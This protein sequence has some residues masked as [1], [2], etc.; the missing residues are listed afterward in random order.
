M[1]INDITKKV[2]QLANTWEEF[3]S[4]NERRLSEIE[5]KSVSDPLTTTQLEKINKAMDRYQQSIDNI[6]AVLNRP[7]V[8]SGLMV[9]E[10]SANREY[11]EAFCK[12][13]KNGAEADLSKLEKKSLVRPA[14]NEAG[15]SIT[16][17]MKEYI[18]AL[19]VQNSSM[20]QISNVIE[21]ST[22]TLEIIEDREGITSGWTSGVSIDESQETAFSK[23]SVHVHELYVQPKVTQKLIDDPMVDVEEWLS[24]KLVNSFVVQENKAFISGDGVGKPRGILS[25]SNI[26]KVESSVKDFNADKVLEL[27]FSIKEIYADDTKFLMSRDALQKIRTLKDKNGQ[28]LWHPNLSQ[29]GKST[30]FGVDVKV[31]TDMPKL[32]VD[33]LPIA[34]GNFNHAYQIVDR[35]VMRVLRDPFTNK[36]FV[37][38]YTTKRV[39][40]DVVNFDSIK[41]LKISA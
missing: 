19:L 8:E 30:L 23:R 41:L 1:N 22:D 9:G 26:E 13:I 35:G 16:H 31:S 5:K 7:N 14:V 24:K 36:P 28:Y 29:N 34:F 4:L 11:K 27:F 10:T 18:E 6:E 17:K 12:Y 20:R 15:Y 21:V 39:G 32:E 37:K 3:K 25:Y 40:G 33:Q 38:F 2:G